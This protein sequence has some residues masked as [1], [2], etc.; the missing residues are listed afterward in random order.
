ML[1]LL[2]RL[3]GLTTLSRSGL[4]KGGVGALCTSSGDTFSSSGT[5][6]TTAASSHTVAENDSQYFIAL[7]PVECTLRDQINFI[8]LALLLGKKDS[9]EES[10]AKLGDT[11]NYA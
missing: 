3:L 6:L 4:I 7:P 5:S 11:N 1:Q 10:L 9:L 2:K 8:N